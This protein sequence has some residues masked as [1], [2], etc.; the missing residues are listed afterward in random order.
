MEY[1]RKRTRNSQGK[2]LLGLDIGTKAIH[3]AVGK[4]GV[5]SID[6]ECLAIDNSETLIS[7]DGKIANINLLKSMIMRTI[8]ENRISARALSC[9]IES[10]GLIKREIEIPKVSAQ[11][12]EGLI[13]YEVASYL[14]IDI[15]SYV[16]QHK[17][18]EY[19]SNP[20]TE[21]QKV[22][23][24][25]MPKGIVEPLVE[26]CELCGLD[27]YSMDSHATVTEN[28]LCMGNSGGR[29]NQF[30][31]KTIAMI[32]MGHSMFNI[33]FYE[34]GQYIFN[35]ILE[36]G[37]LQI[38]KEIATLFNVDAQEAEQIKIDMC[39][40]K[41]VF[42]FAKQSMP[43]QS[44]VSPSGSEKLATELFYFINN[45][46]DEVSAVLRYYTTRHRNNQIDE[47]VLHG[48]CAQIKDIDLFFEKRSG[49]KTSVLRK[50]PYLN[51]SP[52]ATQDISRY[53]NAIS[54]I[55][56]G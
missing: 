15:S 56:V 18:L 10:Q 36:M 19:D 28:L 2:V 35:R 17:V 33:S 23:V 54:C 46:F 45:W 47:I 40:R 21:T 4:V 12:I 32:D 16:V 42:E 25:A 14:P 44:Q 27:H 30:Y 38:D 13:T 7:V 5:N 55:A 53:I 52:T 51:I 43:G 49:I 31:G 9:T 29:R 3:V 41:S 1:K 34:N 50:L 6:I 37:G 11:D 8:A 39:Q 22:M 26:V 48:G 20:K 24:A